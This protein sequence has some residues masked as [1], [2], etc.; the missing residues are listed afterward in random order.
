MFW[1]RI[2]RTSSKRS[3]QQGIAIQLNVAAKIWLAIGI[4]LLG[5]VFC[6]ALEQIQ[7]RN[8][9]QRLRDTSAGLFPAA[10]RSQEAEAAFQSA[11]RGFSDAVVIQDAVGL[12]RAMD[13]GRHVVDHLRA[14]AAI[15]A[16]PDGQ[17]EE[18]R[19]LAISAAEFLGQAN[20]TYAR[21]VGHPV[22]MTAE[23]QESMR[24]LAARTSV[25]NDAL[26]QLK[27]RVS[28][29]LQDNLEALQIRSERN[30]G[31]AL[32]VFLTT[33]LVAS[34]L[35][36]LTIRH[37]ITIPLLRAE[38]DLHKSK[39][40]AE[41]AS[42]AKS[43]FLANMSHEIRTPMNGILGMAELAMSATGAE[44]QEYLAVVRSSGE[45]LLGILND[46][47]DYSKIEAGKI[48]LDPVPFDL[49]DVVSAS[50]KTLALSAHKKG[51]DLV[52]DIDLE[53]PRHIVADPMRLRQVLL[54][55][56][57]NAI[58]FTESG[59][60]VVR[61]R[62]DAPAES[63]QMLSFAVRDTGMGIPPEKQGKLF[64]AFEQ[65]DSSTTRQ[66]GG[67]GLGLAISARIVQLMGGRIWMN[68]TPGVGTTFHFT[69]AFEQAGR[70]SRC[71]P[72]EPESLHGVRVLII[73]KHPERRRILEAM[74]RCWRMEVETAESGPA[75][76]ARLEEAAGRRAFR[77]LV[78]DG[79]TAPV[80]WFAAFQRAHPDPAG[81][82]GLILLVT[83]DSTCADSTSPQDLSTQTRLVKPIRPDDL[84]AAICAILGETQGLPH[85]VAPLAAIQPRSLRLRILVAEDSPV[86]QKLA[87]AMLGKMGHSVAIAV[88]GFDAVAKW[89]EGSLDLILMD[90][91]M[92]ELDGYEA[93]RRIRSL[94]QASC[95]I[96]IIAMT[97]HA[98]A[99]DRDRCLA[100][101]MDD[102]IAKPVNS[103]ELER[104]ILS[105]L[106]SLR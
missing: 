13:D 50:L 98:M 102:H 97:A 41:A 55:L 27:L 6:T 16:L 39:E 20:G 77:V 104:V 43:E 61:V 75:G 4:F 62:R 36:N 53:T 90:I 21:V 54:N 5:F 26:K 85:A 105:T 24:E 73:D 74:T 11:V 68:S 42:R 60:V 76:L 66:Y 99:G 59:E 93:A 23:V 31:L 103:K 71:L 94:E 56:V 49:V 14:V 91:Q 84:L 3:A 101:G 80:D 33:L 10:L 78:L 19:R 88:N 34:V 35:V 45:S 25:L 18:A 48:T 37:A 65:G 106:Y 46:I 15:Q 40:A 100:A 52:L 1:S 38:A 81:R 58:K 57:G 82:C 67:T 87:S 63:A 70:D 92:P 22:N 95:H 29:A 17:A 72:M 89:R 44:Q 7:G 79:N 9:E 96:P 64:Q 83:A 12:D 86:N 69:V 32:I 28:R 8:T 47:L 2:A 30:R 51:L